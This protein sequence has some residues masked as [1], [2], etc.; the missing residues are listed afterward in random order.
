VARL[1]FSPEAEANLDAIAAFIAER[2]GVAR[3]MVIAERIWKTMNNLA[4]MPGIG[5]KRSYLQPDQRAF[6]VSPWT[7]FYRNLPDGYGIE[8]VRVIDGRR[9]LPAIFS[10]P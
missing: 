1:V 8:I 2:D 3:A 10:A 7:I 4:F 9:D 6:P 5:Q